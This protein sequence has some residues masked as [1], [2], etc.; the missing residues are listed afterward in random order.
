MFVTV[1]SWDEW[2]GADRLMKYTEPNVEK[3]K[4]LF[5]DQSGDKILKGRIPQT[6]P[7]G[8]TG[9][10]HVSHILYQCLMFFFV[11][12]LGTNFE[13]LK[14]TSLCNGEKIS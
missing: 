13:A 7:K 4:K 3:R 14:A 6:K 12:T 1:G 2:V 8:T 11:P 9:N 10:M 5:K